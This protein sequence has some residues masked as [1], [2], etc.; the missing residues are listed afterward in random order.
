MQR[1]M[2]LVA[3]SCSMQQSMAEE[4]K[5]SCPPSYLLAFFHGCC[6]LALAGGE[7]ERERERAREGGKEGERE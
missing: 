5:E 7:S 1:R 6:L 4:L 2:E 3:S